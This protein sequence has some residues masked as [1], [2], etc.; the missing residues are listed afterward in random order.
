VRGLLLPLL[1]TPLLPLL[2]LLPLPAVMC[3]LSAAASELTAWAG[4]CTATGCMVSVLE[5][6]QGK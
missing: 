3:G 5:D 2:L 6:D 1:L 4:A